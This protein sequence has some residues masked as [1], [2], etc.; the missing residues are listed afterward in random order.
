ML[1]FA[2]LDDPEFYLLYKDEMRIVLMLGLC[3]GLRLHDAAC[4]QWN[5]I[6]GDTVEFKPAKTKRRQREALILPYSS[7]LNAL[8]TG[9]KMNMFCQM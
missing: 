7:N 5:Y 2:K 6:K 3:F 1:F 8:P 4:F 9:N